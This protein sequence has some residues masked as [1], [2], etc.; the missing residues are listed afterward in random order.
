MGF[1]SFDNFTKISAES[2][3][4]E[5][6][7]EAL[8]ESE[9]II[10]ESDIEKAKNLLEEK[11]IKFEERQYTERETLTET[12]W[13]PAE[14]ILNIQSSEGEDVDFSTTLLV[15]DFLKENEVTVRYG[16]KPETDQTM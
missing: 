7:I 8:K 12:S 9:L 11:G 13:I 15:L 16:H 10:P 14:F 5:G 4:A 2:T 6:G 1:E 3:T